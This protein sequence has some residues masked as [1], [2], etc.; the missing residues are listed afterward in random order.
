[1]RFVIVTGMSGAGKSTA[2]KML[3]DM[4]YFCVDNLPILLL[5]KF[6]E[7]ACDLGSEIEKVALGVDVRSGQALGEL[8]QELEEIAMEGFQYEIVFLDASDSVLVKRYKETRRSHPL[9]R[10][11]RVDKGIALER[12]KMG[13]LKKHADYIIDTSQL[14][15]RELHQELGKIF[16]WNQEFKSLVITVLSFGF[17]YGIPNDCDLVFDVRF[18]PN[19]FYVEELRNKTGL[20]AEVQD[21][22]MGFELAHEFLDK[23]ADMVEFLIPNYVAEGKNQLVIGIGCTGGKH[24]SV[25]LAGRLYE[26]L[27]TCSEY[28]SRIEHRDIAR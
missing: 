26:R 10:G 22:V 19:P 4:G 24:R 13:F 6:A 20:D 1:M 17:K 9:S 11:D 5:K 14:L 27:K 3:E 21:Y 18:L 25:T 16:V 15:T 28:G 8:E 23:L 12:A 7:L 2:L